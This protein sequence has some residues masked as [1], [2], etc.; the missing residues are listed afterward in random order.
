M[1]LY[2]CSSKITT[3][4]ASCT[5]FRALSL[6][7]RWDV[8]VGSLM[9]IEELDLRFNVANTSNFRF[10][11]HFSHAYKLSALGKGVIHVAVLLV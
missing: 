8:L 11:L 2:S 9:A 5:D 7:L 1:K 6:S 10:E 4:K 3:A